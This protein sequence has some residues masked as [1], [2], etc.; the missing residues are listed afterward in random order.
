M[1]ADKNINAVSFDSAPRIFCDI[2]MSVDHYGTSKWNQRRVNRDSSSCL[3][4]GTAGSNSIAVF[5]TAD[6][7]GTIV[8]N[9]KYSEAC[10]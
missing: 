5:S 8:C 4:S 9:F 2:G 10:T 7:A 6:G 3:C 1:T